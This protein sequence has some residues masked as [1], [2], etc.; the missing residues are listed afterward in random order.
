M[1]IKVNKKLFHVSEG[2]SFDKFIKE[3][4]YSRNTE[5]GDGDK[6]L[7][8]YIKVISDN[9]DWRKLK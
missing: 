8:K 7:K 5:K 9:I 3:V 2:K 1:S 4:E 6:L